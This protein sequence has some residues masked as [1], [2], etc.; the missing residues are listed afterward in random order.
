ME[1]LLLGNVAG[2]GVAHRIVMITIRWGV[3]DR[4]IIM[5]VGVSTVTQPLGPDVARLGHTE[6]RSTCGDSPV[7]RRSV[8]TAARASVLDTPRPR[9]VRHEQAAPL[10]MH[11]VV[12]GAT[13]GW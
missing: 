2:R 4:F 12:T 10:T 6:G 7:T 5:T 3:V 13:R 8:T 1:A 11:E 9:S